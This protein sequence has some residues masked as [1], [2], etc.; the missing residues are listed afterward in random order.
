[1]TGKNLFR[2]VPSSVDTLTLLFDDISKKWESSEKKRLE[3]REA[4]RR[5][6]NKEKE[7]DEFKGTKLRKEI[8]IRPDGGRR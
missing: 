3:E 6:A 1:M 7:D 2:P 4:K 8:W 5:E